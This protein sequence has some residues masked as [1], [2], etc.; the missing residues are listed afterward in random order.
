MSIVNII[1]NRILALSA[2]HSIELTDIS[3]QYGKSGLQWPK[4][5]QPPEHD[6]KLLS[7][8]LELLDVLNER[9]SATEDLIEKLSAQD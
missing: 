9:I 4:V 3:D 7:E 5:L 2:Q 6:G 1:R 8:D